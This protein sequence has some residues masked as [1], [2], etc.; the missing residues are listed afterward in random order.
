MQ[1]YDAVSDLYYAFQ[2]SFT[3]WKTDSL[4]APVVYIVRNR[5]T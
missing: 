1:L 4:D 5:Y 2:S 3:S